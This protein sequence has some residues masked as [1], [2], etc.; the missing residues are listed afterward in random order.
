MNH[1]NVAVYC[2]DAVNMNVFSISEFV[3]CIASSLVVGV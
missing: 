2:V 1:Q 3:L